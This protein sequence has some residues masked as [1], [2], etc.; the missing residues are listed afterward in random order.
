MSP[1]DRAPGDQAWSPQLWMVVSDI[2]QIRG[3]GTVLTGLLEG[4]GELH[5]G[6]TLLCDGAQCRVEGIEQFQRRLRTTTPGSTVGIL[7]PDGVD[8]ELLRGNTVQF[9]P[10]GRTSA[11]QAGPQLGAGTEKKRWR[12]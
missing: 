9:Q 8:P 10:K 1:T 3:R 2:F 4:D 6:D 7:I 5:I 11:A 12:R